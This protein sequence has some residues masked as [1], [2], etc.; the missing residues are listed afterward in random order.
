MLRFPVLAQE[1]MSSCATGIQVFL[2]HKKTCVLVAPEN[3]SSCA[4]GKH[5]FLSD[6][7]PCVHV[8]QDPCFAVTHKKTRLV[9]PQQETPNS[10]KHHFY[11]MSERP[12]LDLPKISI[13]LKRTIFIP[14][15]LGPPDITFLP[16]WG[17]EA[18]G[19]QRWH[20]FCVLSS[21][22]TKNLDFLSIVRVGGEWV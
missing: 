21:L 16:L 14:C 7:K 9:V 4:T 2:C 12:F 6:R 5:V 18:V 11:T 19:G 15:V 17:L 13:Y 1:R 20:H 3:M 10:K 22:E 8:A